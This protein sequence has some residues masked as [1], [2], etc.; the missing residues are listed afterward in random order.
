MQV[1][2]FVESTFTSLRW[3]GAPPIGGCQDAVPCSCRKVTRIF[4]M[5]KLRESAKKERSVA[6]STSPRT[7]YTKPQNTKNSVSG[8]ALLLAA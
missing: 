3:S 6:W 5:K 8:Q 2:R 1:N 4:P 7:G